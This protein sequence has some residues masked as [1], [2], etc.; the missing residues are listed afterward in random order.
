MREHK[1][2]QGELCAKRHPETW[3]ADK[4]MDFLASASHSPHAWLIPGIPTLYF[5]FLI[6]N[7]PFVVYFPQRIVDWVPRSLSISPGG[8]LSAQ[9]GDSCP[10]KFKTVQ[11]ESDLS[12]GENGHLLR[13]PRSEN[14][15]DSYLVYPVLTHN[16]DSGSS[17]DLSVKFRDGHWT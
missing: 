5:L 14:E 11:V 10:Q 7:V 2:T 9:Q 4:W 3:G 6:S 12:L 1:T 16:M 8:R 17:W 15:S 13:W